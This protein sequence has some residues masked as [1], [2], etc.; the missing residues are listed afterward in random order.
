MQ[1]P[2]PNYQTLPRPELSAKIPNISSKIHSTFRLLRLNP[3][4]HTNF[5]GSSWLLDEV[6]PNTPN[7]R[8]FQAAA[9]RCNLN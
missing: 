1:F 2:D 5:P 6:S 4:H 9:L 7:P 3:S 8:S